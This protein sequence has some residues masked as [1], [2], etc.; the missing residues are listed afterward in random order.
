MSVDKMVEKTKEVLNKQR[1]LNSLVLEMKEEVKKVE[2]MNKSLKEENKVLKEKLE[3]MKPFDNTVLDSKVS[4]K[5]V[6]PVEK[7]EK[8]VEIKV[9]SKKK[10]NNDY[11]VS[12]TNSVKKPRRE[13]S[14]A[15]KNIIEFFLGKNVV[16]KI[17]AVLMILAVITFGQIAYVDF[18]DDLG[19]FILIF[20]IG[21]GSTLLAYFFERKKAEVFHNVFY[22]IGLS[23]LLVD[24]FLGLYEYELYNSVFFM[25]Y[26]G[27]ITVIP[28]VYFY[29]KRY[30]FLDLALLV[31]YCVILVSPI[32][33]FK[34]ETIEI[35]H[36]LLI[37]VSLGISGYAIYRHFM[38][39]IDRN[40]NQVIFDYLILMITGILVITRS[41]IITN[42]SGITLAHF[43]VFMYQVYITVLYYFINIKTMK[44]RQMETKLSI[45]ISSSIIFWLLGLGY[46]GT[47]NELTGYINNSL[48]PLIV[49]VL[50]LPIY[51]ILFRNKENKT[52][53]TIYLL[54]IA[55]F[56]FIYTFT[57][58]G[59][60]PRISESGYEP[61]K[62]FDF[63]VKNLVL[64][65]EVMLLF[66][67]SVLTKDKIQKYVS[68]GF[69]LTVFFVSIGPY[70]LGNS[71]YTFDDW[72]LFVPSIVSGVFV[73][74]LCLFLSKDDETETKDVVT[75]YF[76]TTLLPFML[77]FTHELILD[78]Q[79]V[80]IISVA[81]LFIMFRQLFR[82][83]IFKTKYM[84]ELI[85]GI[86]IGFVVFV[87]ISNFHYFNH[88]FRELD[89]VL[90]FFIVFVANGLLILSLREINTYIV[91][92]EMIES[93]EYAFLTF[94]ILGVIIQA[95]FITTYI[96]FEF[97]KVI[98]SSYY[99]IA[100]AVGVLW[101]FRKNWYLVRKIGL[102]AIY[103]SLAKFF[104]YDFLR[105]D[106]TMYVRFLSYF[107]LAC[108]LF[109]ISALYS[110]LEK[111]YGTVENQE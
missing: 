75:L 83:D 105:N 44:D 33:V 82:L 64:V 69:M 63:Y 38:E 36:F 108:V 13:R 97:D 30:S 78:D 87:L 16:V 45:L 20:S 42:G 70:V 62:Q 86:N 89:D 4:E 31:Y 99:M 50:V 98:L 106:F 67:A 51:T 22:I 101:G 43:N 59:G 66:L 56:A 2:S 81:Y 11:R 95:I 94:Y 74:V 48:G 37:I 61:I 52:I 103:F 68:Y 55:L 104:V 71:D 58:H 46:N 88:N 92:K 21:I 24:N 91:E 12:L 96:N 49:L 28:L 107:I 39:V 7:K 90:K 35:T 27:V 8:P 40:R 54:V 73:F 14:E 60:R 100:A 1:E 53:T 109:G 102:F 93:E 15:E 80:V 34:S 65:V 6:S 23:V 25:F 26:L 41:G 85:F 32:D 84:K 3:M 76:L 5:V 57:M 77:V 79:A 19:R 18:L 72:N 29:H 111:V 110:Y 9:E 47:I 10:S 17:A